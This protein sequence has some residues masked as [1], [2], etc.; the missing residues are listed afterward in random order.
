MA[1]KPTLFRR[2]IT[3]LAGTQTT[4]PFAFRRAITLMA[5][6]MKTPNLGLYRPTRSLQ[7]KRKS[8][9]L[10]TDSGIFQIR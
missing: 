1:G 5:G 2:V 10:A 3:R 6:M 7:P 4:A 9:K 8:S